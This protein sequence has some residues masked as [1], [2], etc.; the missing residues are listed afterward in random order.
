MMHNF[1]KVCCF[2]QSIDCLSRQCLYT[3]CNTT[4][5]AH[6]IKIQKVGFQ[7]KMKKIKKLKNVIRRNRI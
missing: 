6:K 5:G 1:H 2:N 7:E 4:S 3:V